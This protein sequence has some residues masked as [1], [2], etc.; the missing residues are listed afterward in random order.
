ML[1]IMEERVRKP[2][3]TGRIAQT[4]DIKRAKQFASAFFL[5]VVSRR[6]S[7]LQE[8]KKKKKTKKTKKASSSY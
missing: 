3:K 2:G 7:N 5:C 6:N 8:L 1:I 4:E